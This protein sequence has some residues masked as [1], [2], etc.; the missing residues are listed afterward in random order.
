MAVCIRPFPLVCVADLLIGEVHGLDL[1]VD[2]GPQ[3]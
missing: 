3:L 2:G 1:N